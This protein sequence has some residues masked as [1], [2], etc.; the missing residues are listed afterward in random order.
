MSRDNETPTNTIIQDE[1]VEQMRT[2][3]HDLHRHPELGFD[4]ERSAEK[5]AELLIQWGLE[6]HSGIGKTGVVA[7]LTRGSSTKS[8][9][10]RCDIDALPI[11]EATDVDYRSR[12]EG[13]MH[14]CGHD[15]HTAMLLGAA[16]HLRERGDFDGTVH[17]LFQPNE[18]HG[19]GAQ[20]ML[21]DGLF[22]RFPS[23]SVFGMHNLPGQQAGTFALRQGPI[24]AAEN[25]FEIEITGRGGH[26]SSPHRCIDPL[27]IAAQI[28]TSLQTIVSRNVDPFETVVV[29]VTE[30]LTDGSRNVIPNRVTLK[31]ESR[32]F[33]ETATGL[34]EERVNS[35][36]QAACQSAGAE[37]DLKFSREFHVTEN[38]AAETA[39]CIQAAVA[40]VGSDSVELDCAPKSFSED[41]ASLARVV[42]GCYVFIGNGISGRHGQMLH[43]P[44][45]D[46]NDEILAIG[47]TYWVRL[48]EQVLKA[49]T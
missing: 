6:V 14:A 24:M 15:G 47:A 21:D 40:V 42:P 4:V 10:L 20:A 23:T 22:E 48:T 11:Q 29:S 7:S 32:T 35:I 31:G 16:K 37:Y 34:V 26:A 5:I 30:I 39:A 18:E 1:L 33:S 3:R 41:F 43:N 2:W 44:K 38:A 19:L 46:F 13:R 8:I 9:S 28:I 12:I 36:V 49:N 45:Y 17:F 25:L 27:V